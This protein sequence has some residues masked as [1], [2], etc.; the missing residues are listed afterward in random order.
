MKSQRIYSI[1]NNNGFFLSNIYNGSCEWT[2]LENYSMLFKS[3]KKAY[4]YMKK[5][6]KLYNNNVCCVFPLKDKFYN[7]WGW[8]Q[9]HSFAV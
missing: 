8:N 3:Y 9:I 6:N 2:A 7:L 1:R 4:Y 5:T